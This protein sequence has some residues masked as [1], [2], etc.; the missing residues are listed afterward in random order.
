M[1]AAD[2]VN[3]DGDIQAGDKLLQ[4]VVVGVI[5]PLKVHGKGLDL[6]DGVFGV[7][8]GGEGIELAGGTGDED[9]IEALGCELQGE[10]FADAVGGT[11]DEGP[12]ATGSVFAKL[13]ILLKWSCV[14]ECR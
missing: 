6:D 10:F 9:D 12:R 11:G 7:D 4:T 13:V 2:V 3:E 1:G 5:V 14:G 8:F